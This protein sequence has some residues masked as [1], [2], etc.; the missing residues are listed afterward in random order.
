[1]HASTVSIA[2]KYFKTT[3]TK[4]LLDLVLQKKKLVWQI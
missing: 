2:T 3:T 4:S 1:M